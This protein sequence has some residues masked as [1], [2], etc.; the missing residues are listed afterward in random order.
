MPIYE[1]ICPDC[2]F[3]FELLRPM[4]QAGDRVSC[5]QCQGQAKRAV[6]SFACF[7]RD[8]TGQTS[9]IGGASCSGCSTTSCDSCGP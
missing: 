7:S 6:S 2:K 8:E 4:S 1:Y 9:S 3:E 5:L